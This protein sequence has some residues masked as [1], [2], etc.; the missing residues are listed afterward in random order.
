MLN[1]RWQRTVAP[2]ALNGSFLSCRPRI[3]RVLRTGQGTIAAWSHERT[4]SSRSQSG[5]VVRPR[6]CPILCLARAGG[7]AGTRRT[8]RRTEK[9][10]S[11]EQPGAETIADCAGTT[12]ARRTEADLHL[13]RCCARVRKARDVVG[14]PSGRPPN[15]HH[16]FGRCD[17]FIPAEFHPEFCRRGSEHFGAAGP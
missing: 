9:A 2:R 10:E 1:D 8:I 6:G 13:S 11:I 16:A 12:R 4:R 5:Q 3:R 14:R 15:P 17:A 7:A